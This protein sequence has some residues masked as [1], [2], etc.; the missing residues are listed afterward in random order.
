MPKKM[1]TARIRSRSHP[2]HTAHEFKDCKKRFNE[3]NDLQEFV[4]HG[5]NLK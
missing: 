3:T 2:A 4:E 1:L 5:L